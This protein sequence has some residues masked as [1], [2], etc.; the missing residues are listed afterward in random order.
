MLSG[1]TSPKGMTTLVSPPTHLFLKKR[2]SS[3]SKSKEETK[4]EEAKGVAVVVNYPNMSKFFKPKAFT[5]H[6]STHLGSIV[7][8]IEVTILE[9]A[10]MIKE[11]EK[12][13]H[14]KVGEEET[15]SICMCELYDGL[16]EIITKGE[17]DKLEKQHELQ[18]T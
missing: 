10:Q 12:M 17:D 13:K 15:C 8:Y 2:A 9:L 11:G 14:R 6:S 4:F 7:K 1:Q 16:H 3:I 18:M 5:N